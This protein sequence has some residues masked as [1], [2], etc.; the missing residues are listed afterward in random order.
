[1]KEFF[2]NKKLRGNPFVCWLELLIPLLA[3]WFIMSGIFEPKFIAYGTATAVVVSLLC[4]NAFVMD[5]LKTDTQYFL[6]NVNYIKF[7]GYFIW[8]M[9]EIIVCALTVS[10][11]VFNGKISP[12]IV[13]FKADYDNP[14]ARA[15]LANSIT[16]TPG[17]VTIDIYDDGVYSVHALDEGAAEGLLAGGMQK[18]IAALYG[19]TIDFKPLSA[20]EGEAR[21]VQTSK[22]SRRRFARKRRR[23]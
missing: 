9:K 22:L 14:V 4:A 17:T 15:L 23:L 12:R 21:V 20:E 3:L 10:K 2:T 8:L 11:Q 1:M 19:E 5:G 6:F 16:L 7:I 13:W 18:K